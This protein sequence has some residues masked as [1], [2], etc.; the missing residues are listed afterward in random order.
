MASGYHQI[1]MATDSI[2]KTVFI[3]PK[4]HYQYLKMSSG[5]VN[6]P[7]VFQRAVYEVLGLKTILKLFE[8]VGLTVRLPT[9]L[10]FKKTIQYLGNKLARRHVTSH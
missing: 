1:L 7:S 10:F 8:G 5:L 3:T 2:P 9:C 6:A 4:A